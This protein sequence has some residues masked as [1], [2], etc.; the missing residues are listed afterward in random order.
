[1]KFFILYFSALGVLVVSLVLAFLMIPPPASAPLYKIVTFYGW[2]VFCILTGVFV[3]IK[4]Q[5]WLLYLAF[6]Q[7]LSYM[8]GF[9]FMTWF[10]LN[11]MQWLPF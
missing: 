9:V 8:F 6:F 4:P 11:H 7:F 2:L 5:K 3:L 10:A 1:M